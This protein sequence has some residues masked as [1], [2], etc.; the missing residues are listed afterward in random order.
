MLQGK[1]YKEVFIETFLPNTKIEYGNTCNIKFDVLEI[2][3]DGNS[4][5]YHTEDLS[6]GIR[7][8]FGRS[9]YFLPVGEYTY[10]IK[11]KTNRQIG[12]FDKFD[13][14]YWNVTGNGWDFL[15]EK[16]QQRSIFRHLFQ[17]M[18]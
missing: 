14:L 13:E 17:A 5:D 11:Y 6:N 4:E 8:Y 7:V 15:I 3:R 12:Y 16:L 9:D 10:S 2:S 1:K 18:I